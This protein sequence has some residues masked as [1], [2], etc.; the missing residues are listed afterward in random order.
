[1]ARRALTVC[2]VPRC[3]NAQPCAEHPRRK[4][5]TRSWRALR[6]QVLQR[7]RFPCSCG[8]LASEVDHIVPREIGGR[9]D[10]ENLRSLCSR[11]HAER[12]GRTG[13]PQSN[14]LHRRSTIRDVAAAADQPRFLAPWSVST[15]PVET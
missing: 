7:D 1:M 13:R 6:L 3:P 10:P 8:A 15:V 9:D 14:W 11:G 12:H 2:T 4:G 5:S